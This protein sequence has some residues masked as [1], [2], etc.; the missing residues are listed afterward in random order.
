MQGFLFTLEL[1]NFKSFRGKQT[2]GPF[3]NFSAIIGPNGSGKSNLMDAIS[4]VLGETAKNLRVKKLADLV[5]GVNVQDAISV[6]C[7][8]KMMFH[9]VDDEANEKTEKTFQRSLTE[10]RV[11]DQ[12]VS[13]GEYHKELEK[14]NI[15]IKARNFLV[16]Q[17]AVEQIAMQGPREMTQLFEELS[18][19]FELRDD[20]ERLKQEMLAAETNAQVNLTRK[21]DI[22]LEMR[23]AK[24]EQMDAK[25]FQ[26]LKQD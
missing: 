22:V 12:K 15:F 20:Y 1:E 7:K 18:K 26:N 13:V 24:Q 17:G 4:F 9:Q 16:Y 19:S 21:K 5:H 3:K 25:R 8:V 23:E 6:N 11:D 10:F 14:I 2:I